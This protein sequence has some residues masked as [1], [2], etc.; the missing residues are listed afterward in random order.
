[1]LKIQELNLVYNMLKS[2][3]IHTCSNSELHNMVI[4]HRAQDNSWTT[5]NFC[6]A[7]CPDLY[8]GLL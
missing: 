6:L 8:H 2:R 5:V 7:Y 1:M 4:I 3:D